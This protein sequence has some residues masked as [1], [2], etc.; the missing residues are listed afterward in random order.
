MGLIGRIEDQQRGKD[1]ALR[2]PMM[3]SLISHF[4]YKRGAISRS[5]FRAE[6]AW[7]D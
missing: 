6:P 1:W 5:S 7:R 4:S 3:E 2:K